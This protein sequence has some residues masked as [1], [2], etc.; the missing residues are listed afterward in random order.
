MHYLANEQDYI[1]F[2]VDGRGSENR[3]RNFEQEIFR[4]L[5]EVEMRDQISGVEH[6]KSLDYVN[7]NRIAV[8]GWSYGG[9]MTTNLMCSYPDVFTWNRRRTG[10]RLEVL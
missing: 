1:V 8:H 5:G 4:N 9:F 2:T 10:N 6:L 7:K 3:G